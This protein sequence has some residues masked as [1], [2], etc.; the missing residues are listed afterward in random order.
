MLNFGVA[1]LQH[2]LALTPDALLM[3][4]CSQS[5]DHQ[6]QLCHVHSRPDCWTTEGPPLSCWWSPWLWRNAAC[7]HYTLALLPFILLC[8]TACGCMLT[9]WLWGN[10][11]G[12][13]HTLALTLTPCHAGMLMSACLQCSKDRLL[14]FVH[15]RLDCRPHKDLCCFAEW[16]LLR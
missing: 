3:S 11:A 10:V 1:C 6:Q 7:L 5:G 12:R 2:T 16:L 14:S 9:T 13:Q 4:S 15:N 8:R